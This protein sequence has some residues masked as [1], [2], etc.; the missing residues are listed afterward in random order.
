L[1]IKQAETSESL[2]FRTGGFI[3]QRISLKIILIT[4]IC[5]VN[6]QNRQQFRLSD[7]NKK[8][9]S[10]LIQLHGFDKYNLPVTYY[11]K[12]L[13]REKSLIWNWDTI[14]V[15]DSMSVGLWKRLTQTF[16]IDNKTATQ[17]TQ[18]WIFNSWVNY[19]HVSYSYD[20][21]GNL[22]SILTQNWNAGTWVN[23]SLDSYSYDGNGNML[24][25]LL[26]TWQNN[27]WMN[28]L[29]AIHSYYPN[30]YLL[31]IVEAE[32]QNNGWVN[33]SS[34]TLTY[35]TNGKILTEVFQQWQVNSWINADSTSYTY[36][37][38]GNM[39]TYL[40]EIWQSG[41]WVNSTKQI[42]SYDSSDL[43]LVVLEEY[44][45]DSTWITSGRI[46]LY[47]DGYGNIVN[48]LYEQWQNNSWVT[49][50]RDTYTYDTYGNSITGEYQQWLN[51][52][53]ESGNG[54]LQIYSQQ[55][56]IWIFDYAYSFE[57]VFR[58]VIN[59]IENIHTNPGRLSVRPNPAMDK[60][61]VAYANFNGKEGGII[62]IYNIQGESV[63]EQQLLSENSEVDVSRFAK[64]IYILEI[65][66][67][68]EKLSTRFIIE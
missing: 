56:S 25:L 3:K 39:L 14:T 47:Y 67:G 38:S 36:D 10:G 31:S 32:W 37:T 35:D 27:A 50:W 61:S 60:I 16:T 64:G 18:L 62:S 46:T 19:T 6:A 51:G 63:L 65:I 30:G 5:I 17:T 26:E 55:S 68:K 59:E 12:N 45:Q 2:I 48:R 11:G 41:V 29:K 54:V 66:C 21:S 13:N 15:Y 44:W 49:S 53:W 33:N 20:S 52:Q 40:S 7:G 1:T 8:N 24:T 58:S 43:P 9:L 34:E 28:V 42:F 23:A 22:L 57:A 4:F